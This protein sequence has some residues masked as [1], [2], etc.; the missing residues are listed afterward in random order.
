[1]KVPYVDLNMSPFVQPL[2]Y[3]PFLT[4]P[5]LYNSPFVQLPFC[6]SPLMYN[7]PFK[8]NPSCITPLT[9]TSLLYNPHLYTPFCNSPFH[10]APFV[11][12]NPT[13]QKA[14]Q[15]IRIL[16]HNLLVPPK[17]FATPDILPPRNILNHRHHPSWLWT[18]SGIT[19]GV[20]EI[21]SFHR[22]GPLAA[23]V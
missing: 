9:T 22:I 20:L 21:D 10:N 23:S 5:L 12:P 1:M 16:C 4:T 6:T 8:K 14:F 17:I 3:H 13:Q 15:G 7:T 18:N 19:A 11:Q 2:L